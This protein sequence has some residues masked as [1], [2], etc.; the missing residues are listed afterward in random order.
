MEEKFSFDVF[1]SHNSQ[2]KREVE[3]IARRLVD[4]EK[5]KPWLDKWNLIPGEP[6][7]ESIERALDESR[8]CIVF[9]GVGGIGPWENEEM[10]AALNIRVRRKGFR[11]I[12]V[13]LTDAKLPEAGMLPLFLSGLTWVDFRSGLDNSTEF[14]RLVAGIH[15]IAPGRDDN[16]NAPSTFIRC[17]YRGLEVFEEE[18]KD[19]FFGREAIIQQIIEALRHTRFMA[20][21]GSSG[22][23]K[24][25]LVRAGLIPQLKSGKLEDSENWVYVTLT[26]GAHPLQE[27]ALSLVKLEASPNPLEKTRVLLRNLDDEKSLQLQ[28]RLFLSGKPKN[29]R[30]FLFIDQFEELM[31]LCKD[32]REREKFLLNLR[33]AVTMSDCPITTLITL[34]ADFIDRFVAQ[35]NMAE[36]LSGYKIFVSPMSD[37]DLRRVIEEPATLV[38][39][40][41]E[42]GLVER[43]LNEVGHEPGSLPLLEDALLQLFEHRSTDNVASLQ[44]YEEIGGVNGAL[45]TR[46]ETVYQEFSPA[47]QKVVRRVLLRL[48]QPGEVMEDTRRRAELTEL[49]ADATQQLIVEKVVERLVNARLLTMSSDIDERQTVDVAHE[50][51]IRG[52]PR[53]H[54][55]ITE[56]RDALRIHRLITEASRKWHSQAMDAGFLYRGIPLS[57]AINWRKKNESLLNKQERE[58]LAASIKAARLRRYL[59]VIGG[60][61]T[62]ILILLALW[63]RQREKEAFRNELTI[64]IMQVKNF[65]PELALR[66][67]MEAEKTSPANKDVESVLRQT[68]SSYQESIVLRGHTGIVWDAEFSAD[69]KYV[70][71]ASADHN[72]RIWETETGRQQCI[73]IGHTGEISRA[74]FSPDG[75]YVITASGDKTARIWDAKT[76]QTKHLLNLHQDELWSADFSPD[77]KHVVTAS[78][79]YTARIWEVESGQPVYELRGHEGAIIRTAYSPTG[80]YVVTASEDKTARVWD[81]QS[82]GLVCELRGHEGTVDRVAFSPDE[83]QLVTGAADNTARIWDTKSGKLL[84]TLGG[85]SDALNSVTFS[86]KGT[87]VVTASKD[88]ISRVLGC[89]DRPPGILSIRAHRLYIFRKIQLE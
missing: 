63:W 87:Y 23:G 61:A 54:G 36:M 53:L 50:A 18:H 49:W 12:P 84:F 46:A 67:A 30:F 17:P 81:A 28:I 73:L 45:A 37:T 14:R 86:P 15:G 51:L 82:G 60:A 62:L 89:S 66:L 9:L 58:F 69:G 75:K 70:V 74:A 13:L 78:H 3:A 2:D 33:T 79:D 25:S 83:K 80:T 38:G 6:W 72:A 77:S 35:R 68:L 47:E 39:L 27:L 10:R 11:V 31:T 34:R 19:F 20:V 57:E 65:D 71:T 29:V 16:P 52:W 40:E 26:P 43:I 21:I 5:L 56:E 76:C 32:E 4:E 8:T 24:S 42:K 44:T 48:T 64:R 1:L 22:S 41:L 85:H 7:Q 88:K 59:I 55:W